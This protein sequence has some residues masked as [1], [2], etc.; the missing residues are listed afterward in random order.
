LKEAVV[1]DIMLSKSFQFPL[2]KLHEQ[3]VKLILKK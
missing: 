3:L 1:Q 2:T